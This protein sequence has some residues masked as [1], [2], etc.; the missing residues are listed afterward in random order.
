MS[1]NKLLGAGAACAAEPTLETV[2]QKYYTDFNFDAWTGTAVNWNATPIMGGTGSRVGTGMNGKVYTINCQTMTIME[3]SEE[4]IKTDAYKLPS[5]AG[6]TITYGATDD[7]FTETTIPDFYGTLITHDDAGNFIIG[8]GFTTGAMPKTWSILEPKSGKVAHF[9]IKFPESAKYSMQRID[10]IG[11]AFGNVL[12]DGGLYVAPTSIYWAN[13]K[14]KTWAQADDVQLIKMINFYCEDI[15]DNDDPANVSADAYIT[16]R[17]N[18]DGHLNNICQPLYNTESWKAA[19]KK[20]LNEALKAGVMLYSKKSGVPYFDA[21]KAEDDSHGIDQ[22]ALLMG[23][24]NDKGVFNDFLSDENFRK[25]DMAQNYSGLAGFDVFELQGDRYFV[26]S[27]APSGAPAGNNSFAVYDADGN[28]LVEHTIDWQTANGYTTLS[29]EPINETSVNIYL[30]GEATKTTIPNFA[31]GNY[32]V[33][34]QYKFTVPEKSTGVNEI[35]VDNENAAPVYYNLQG[36]EVANP[37]NG[38]Y[39]V[40]RGSKVTKEIIRK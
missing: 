21:S 30:F 19:D 35:A 18:L 4:G 33:A 16:D 20:N 31:E 32:G 15:E 8:H 39:V 5:L 13:I 12:Q 1:E 36:V 7:S 9:D 3:L 14:G 11:R 2:W 23:E 29:Y 25:S 22:Y 6:R 40:R 28:K 17:V 34:G 26:A 24:Y 10:A 37:E 38:I 27:T